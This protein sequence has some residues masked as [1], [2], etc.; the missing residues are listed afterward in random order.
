[1]KVTIVRTHINTN[2]TVA[3][4]PNRVQTLSRGKH[5]KNCVT[6]G[7]QTPFQLTEMIQFSKCLS[8]SKIWPAILKF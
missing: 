1:M 2:I 7:S 4:I 3:C 6:S 8:N 5:L